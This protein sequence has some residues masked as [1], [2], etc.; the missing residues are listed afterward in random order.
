MNASDLKKIAKFTVKAGNIG[1]E[2]AEII[3][4]ELTRKELIF[5]FRY[6]GRTMEENT[7]RVFSQDS[8]PELLRK[9][10]ARKFYPKTVIF[11]KDSSLGAGI[12]IKMNDTVINFSVGSY[13]DEL[14]TSLKN[15][16]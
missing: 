15:D 10:L 6:L 13:L 5:L 8:I 2:I 12:K 16:L 4:S 9:T 1:K 14:V 7:V 11:D 3:L